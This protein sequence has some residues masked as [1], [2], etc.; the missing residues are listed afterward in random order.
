[1]ERLLEDISFEAEDRAGEHL[2]IDAAYVE[3]QLSS[4]SRDNDLSRFIL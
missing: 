1:M 2:T 4:I 3:S